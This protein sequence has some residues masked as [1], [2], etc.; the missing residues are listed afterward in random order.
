MVPALAHAE[1][2]PAEPQQPVS[3]TK[4]TLSTPPQPTRRGGFVVGLA[5]GVGVASIV[6]YPN[7]SRKEG[8][9]SWYTA[10]GARPS[11]LG[12][13]WIGNAFSDWFVFGLGFTYSPLFATGG[14]KARSFGGLFHIEA[15]PLYTFGGHLR[16]LG[17]MLDAGIGTATVTDAMSNRLVDGSA[18]AL[19][20]GGV[21]YEVVRTWKIGQGPFLMGNY[22]WSDTA[23]RPAIYAGWRMSLYTKP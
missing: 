15:F 5:A 13:L 6:G 10:T 11:A 1:E 2:P 14:D 21:F 23:I 19:I 16:D 9:A 7:D 17:I 22:V 3:T 12:Q 4:E 8:Y 18:A 20:G